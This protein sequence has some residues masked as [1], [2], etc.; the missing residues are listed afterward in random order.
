MKFPQKF[1]QDLLSN[2]KYNSFETLIFSEI[3]LLISIRFTL[4]FHKFYLKYVQFFLGLPKFS[5]NFS[6]LPKFFNK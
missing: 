1:S 5:K 2:F 4:N 6:I 3:L